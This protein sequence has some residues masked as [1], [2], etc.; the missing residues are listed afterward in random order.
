MINEISRKLKRLPYLSRLYLRKR[1]K[2]ARAIIP[3][4]SDYIKYQTEVYC[5]YESNLTKWEKGQERC[6]KRLFSNLNRNLKILD[7]GCGDG[8]GLRQFKKLGFKNVTGFDFHQEKVKKAKKTGY[9]VLKLDMHELKGLKDKEFDIV[10]S[11]HTLEHAYFV[12]KASRELKRVLKPKGLLF[13]VLP[14]PDSL[15]TNEKAHCSKYELGLDI[16]DQGETVV[17][18][19]TKRGFKL[20]EKEFNDFREPEIWLKFRKK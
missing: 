19:F 7:S 16:K 8:V 11:S 17:N 6:I 20:L 4:Y 15:R 2:S 9:R 1:P 12:N 3:R 5:S 13:I 14:Y 18:Y 10:Y